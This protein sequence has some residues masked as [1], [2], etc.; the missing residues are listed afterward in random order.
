MFDIVTETAKN[1]GDVSKMI[2]DSIAAVT[3]ALFKAENRQMAFIK[4]AYQARVDETKKQTDMEIS[5]YKSRIKEIDTELKMMGRKDADAEYESMM[6]RL[7][8][9]LEYEKDE[10]NRYEIEKEI[11]RINIE[12]DKRKYRESLVHEKEA[13]NEMIQW[14]K[15]LY[16]AQKEFYKEMLSVQLD[17]L[18]NAVDLGI[19]RLNYNDW[20]GNSPYTFLGQQYGSIVSTITEIAA[21]GNFAGIGT[22]EVNVYQNINSQAMTPAQLARETQIALENALRYGR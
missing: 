16:A 20:Y 4:R 17:S 13:L 9:S 11:E 5:V 7:N 19:E 3:E 8:A 6:R 18:R 15:D 22:G 21:L 12:N 1:I 2:G 10:Y 14:T